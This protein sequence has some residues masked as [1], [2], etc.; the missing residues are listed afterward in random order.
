MKISVV[1]PLYN[2]KHT[3]IETVKSIQD[4]TFQ[5]LEV[6]IVN[7]G[8]T[9]GSEKLIKDC[10]YP[11]VKLIT[12]CNMGVSSA[13]NRG[14]DEAKGEWIAF[15]DADDEWDTHYLE[16]IKMLAFTYPNCA[17]LATA[18]EIE[19]YLGI[20]KS[21]II[22]RLQITGEHGILDNYFE[23]AS[24]SNP[25][26]CSSAVAVKKES[27]LSIGGFPV[28]VKAGEDLLTWAKLSMKYKIAYSKRI[29]SVFL[30]DPSHSILEIPS[31]L[32][33]EDDFVGRELKEIYLTSD[34][35]LRKDIK[36]Y[37]SLWYKMR[38]SVYLR[39]NERPKVWENS[40]RSIKFDFFNYKNYF[41]LI[42]SFMPY[43]LQRAIAKI[44]SK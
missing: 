42:L 39:N 41:F 21:A 37:I 1:I 16:T 2:K 26:L 40:L 8:S 32:P 23:V 28:G 13:R 36:K 20:R 43:R 22:K 18:Y 10:N 38:A 25:P 30:L 11:I 14:I 17:V 4:Q 5:P 33:D 15:L 12:Q 9:D 44:Y 31:R 7:D 29:L 27:I 24:C 19:D 35:K 6:I 3:I 34:R